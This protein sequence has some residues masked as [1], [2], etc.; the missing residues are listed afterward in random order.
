MASA[1]TALMYG[2]NF[3]VECQDRLPVNSAGLP[4]KKV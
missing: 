4:L 1:D 2:L 3:Q